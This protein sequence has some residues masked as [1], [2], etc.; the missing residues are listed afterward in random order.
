MTDLK[1]CRDAFEAQLKKIEPN[2]SLVQCGDNYAGAF[3]QFDWQMWQAAWI[4][5]RADIVEKPEDVEH[6][7]ERGAC[8]LSPCSESRDVIISHSSDKEVA[9]AVEVAK[10]LYPDSD[11]VETLIR[12]ATAKCGCSVVRPIKGLTLGSAYE[13]KIT[14][15]EALDLV[16]AVINSQ[17]AAHKQK[18]TK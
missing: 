2:A 5:S 9:K 7:C 3:T 15:K 6:I 12:A 13:G 16:N 17:I 14:E 1:P 11:S 8:G 4:A 10:D 18:D